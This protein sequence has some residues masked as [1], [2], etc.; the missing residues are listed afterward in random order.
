MYIIIYIYILKYIYILYIYKLLYIYIYIYYYIYIYIY[1]IYIY[2]RRP[3]PSLGLGGAAPRIT[4]GVRPWQWPYLCTIC[5]HLRNAENWPH[6]RSRLCQPPL[7]TLKPLQ[8]L[9]T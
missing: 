9:K 4:A 2:I 3:L 8:T 5:Q 6:K 1:Y 7:E